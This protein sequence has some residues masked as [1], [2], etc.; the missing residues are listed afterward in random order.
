M[1][2]IRRLI[3]FLSVMFILSALNVTA[4]EAVERILLFHSDITV[5]QDASMTVTETIRVKAEGE[6][7]NHGIYR[8][9]PVRYSDLLGNSYTVEFSVTEV[10]KDGSSEPYHIDSVD[11]GQRVYIGSRDVTIPPG[12]YAY[13]ITYRTDRQIGFFHDYDELYWN[14]TGNGWEFPID[15]ASASVYLPR[16]AGK[17]VIST[18]GYTGFHGAKEKDFKKVIDTK[19]TVQF[20]TT[21]PLLPNEGLS[22]AVSWPKGIVKE[23]GRAARLGYFFSDNKGTIFGVAGLLLLLLYYLAVWSRFGKDPEAGIIVARYTPPDGMSPAVM[24]YITKMG[25]DERVFASAVISLA[26]K[27][28]IAITEKDGEYTLRKKDG[29]KAPLAP[30]EES[31]YKKLLGTEGE[32][33][34]EKT[35]HLKIGSAVEALKDS[36]KLRYEKSYF[37]TNLGYFAAGFLIS[38]MVIGLSGFW[39]SRQKGMLPP[40]LFMCVWLT[41]W[42][43]AV[44]ALMSQVIQKWKAVFRGGR[45]MAKTGGACS[46][47]VFAIPFFAGEIGGILFLGFVT[48]VIT[49]GILIIAVA[50]NLLFYHL[51]KAPTR[52]GRKI[53]DTVEGFRVFLSATEK[54]RMNIL[55]PPEK[56]PELFEQYLPYALALDVEQNWA[57]QFSSIFPVMEEGR[58]GYSP[59]WYS[60]TTGLDMSTGDFVSSVNSS[61]AGAISS[62]STAPGSSSGSGGGGSS[63]GGGGGGGGGGW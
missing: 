40:F 11:N 42:S 45:R 63:G 13:T 35:N 39:V 52:A 26:V 20:F 10:L 43:I 22:I 24:R 44:A 46:S 15:K 62:S 8:D 28:Y 36:L 56:T 17:K 27:G 57:E 54:D 7:I 50:V 14:V 29:G 49:I 3:I 1:K 61:L 21:A 31:S 48:S 33:T 34:L 9:F 32:I 18:D 38:I 5:H 6:K 30:E 59:L 53:L 4:A 19:G 55:N 23:P 58:R 60:G 47:T 25:Y 2:K 12:E 41:F 16:D 51:L 37:V